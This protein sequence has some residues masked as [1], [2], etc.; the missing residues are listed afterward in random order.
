M[1]KHLAKQLIFKLSI[2]HEYL[3]QREVIHNTDLC[4]LG[5]IV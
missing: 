2:L 4:A 5:N 3:L 1:L